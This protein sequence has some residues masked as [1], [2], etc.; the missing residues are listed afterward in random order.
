MG[1][2]VSETWRH[3]PAR[4]GRQRPEFRAGAVEGDPRWAA[5][6]PGWG[7]LARD[8]GSSLV[9]PPALQG[10]ARESRSPGHGPS[11]PRVAVWCWGRRVLRAGKGVRAPTEEAGG[12][13]ALSLPA[14]CP[15]FV[16]PP[17]VEGPP[18][19]WLLRLSC[20]PWGRGQPG[21]DWGSGVGGT[22]SPSSASL[23][24]S[25]TRATSTQVPAAV[26]CGL[27]FSPGRLAGLSMPVCD[28]CPH[29]AV[30]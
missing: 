19:P 26:R 8:Q 12:R 14:Q 2:G 11:W 20:C 24:L 5:Q 28:S 7:Q 17:G 15:G 10:V 22:P 1:R 16:Q 13:S 4:A 29:A 6:P 23:C 3:W 18:G 30:E 9:P 27:W 21:E 25:W